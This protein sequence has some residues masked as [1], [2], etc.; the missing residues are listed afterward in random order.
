MAKSSY[1]ILLLPA[2]LGSLFAIIVGCLVLFFALPS[3]GRQ[4]EYG[5]SLSPAAGAILFVLL[6]LT[7]AIG[8]AIAA[9]SRMAERG[10]IMLDLIL[11][12]FGLAALAFFNEWAACVGIIMVVAASMALQQGKRGSALLLLQVL[13]DFLLAKLP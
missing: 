2:I 1:K 12:L 3:L 7:G 10:L 5:Y 11:S 6:G 13:L 8:A 9:E 4:A